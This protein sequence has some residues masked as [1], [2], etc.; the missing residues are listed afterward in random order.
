MN[1]DRIRELLNYVVQNNSRM[2]NFTTKKEITKKKVPKASI[3]RM[4]LNGHYLESIV[5]KFLYTRKYIISK[6]CICIYFRLLKFYQKLI[7]NLDSSCIQPSYI[8]N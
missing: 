8:V 4:L 2:K 1:D 3:I 5:A 6:L 7:I